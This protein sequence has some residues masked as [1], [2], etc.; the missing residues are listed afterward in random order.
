MF[1]LHNQQQKLQRYF[2]GL[3]KRYVDTPREPIREFNAAFLNYKTQINTTW[4]WFK[5]LLPWTTQYQTRQECSDK[6]SD[7]YRALRSFEQKK[8]RDS[9]LKRKVS[10][11]LIKTASGELPQPIVYRSPLTP[12]PIKCNVTAG[13]AAD[14]VQPYF[15]QKLSL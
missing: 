3:Q 9:D 8:N 5:S 11:E 2:E 10:K 4:K 13:Q 15:A 1:Y 12:R 14:G 6:I 7:A